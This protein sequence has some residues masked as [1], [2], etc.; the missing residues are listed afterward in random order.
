GKPR[1]NTQ[2][3]TYVSKEH[4]GKY[5]SACIHYACVSCLFHVP[6]LDQLKSHINDM[7]I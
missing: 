2:Q 6:D 7:H 3:Y 5:I 4:E 1:G